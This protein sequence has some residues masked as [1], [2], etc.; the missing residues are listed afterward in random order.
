MT[1][2]MIV[3]TALAAF[4]LAGAGCKKKKTDGEPVQG[5]GTA[6]MDSG[7]AGGTMAS[8]SGM[9]GSAMGSG[10]AM[11]GSGSATAP[12][13]D[14]ADKLEIF[15]EHVDPA[16]PAVTV[17]FTG[18]KVVKATFDPEKIEGGTAELEVD[19]STLASGVDKRDTHLKS[20]DYL[21]LGKF[22]KVTIKVDNVK[23]S[24]DN[25]YTA[26]ATINAHGVEKKL[27]V[28]FTV[29]DK[30]ADSIRINGEAKFSRLDFTV[31]KP[32]TEDGSKTAM[33]A[34]LQVT[35]HKS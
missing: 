25:A 22:P 18:V 35:L 3:V 28:T 17:T 24:G 9:A 8:G 14:T 19:I 21:D 23:K 2:K 31:G 12:T 16:K 11:A 20:P 7:S 33:T 29:A 15:A 30:T 5:S 6:T 26:D 32:E 1:K 13:A 10:S 4:A 34:K 27:P